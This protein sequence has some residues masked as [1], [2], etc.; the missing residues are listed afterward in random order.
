MNY[1]CLALVLR[2]TDG[3]SS[4]LPFPISLYSI[5]A[6]TDLVCSWIKLACLLLLHFDLTKENY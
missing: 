6:L 1:S 2:Y 4:V 5:Y 3:I